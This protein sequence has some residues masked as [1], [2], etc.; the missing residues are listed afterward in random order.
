M[1]DFVIRALLAG[2]GVA[3]VAGPLGC[4]VVWRRMAYFG[5]TLA[6]SALLGVA[7]GLAFRVSVTAGIVGVAALA[8]MLLAGLERQRTLAVDTALG[9]LSHG[10]LALGLIALTF[11]EGVRVDLLA[12]LFGDLLAVTWGDLYWIYGASAAA[13]ALMAALWRP[14]LSAAV[15]EDLARVEGVNVALLRSAFMVLFAIV[16]A[17]ALKVVGVLLVTSLLIIPAAAARSLA[18]TP[19]QMAALAI[20]IGC[21][22]VVMGLAGSLAWDAPTGPS[23][24]VAAVL[25]FA[26]LWLLPARRRSAD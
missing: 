5:D 19:E 26:I 22:A 21:L 12:Y 4:F 7:L 10:A 24:V 16:I 3:L 11:L 18:R 6:H 25:L 17:S 1:D 9:I 14:L 15:H 20:V 2:V 23:V 13:L 8:A